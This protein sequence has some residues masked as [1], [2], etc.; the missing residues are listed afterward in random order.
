[1]RFTLVAVLGPLLVTTCVYV[2][3]LFA[4]TGTGL[5]VLLTERSAVLATTVF[6]VTLLLL[7]FGSAVVEET[8][9]VWAR[10]VPDATV[11]GTVTTKVKFAVVFAPMFAVS[12]HLRVMSEQ[13]QPAG[14]ESDTAVVPAGR[15]SV[16][17][18]ALAVAWP[19]L[20]TD[21]V[22]VMLFP[23]VTGFGL[24]TFVTLRSACAA[25]ATGIFT[26]AELLAAF[27]SRVVVPTLTVSEM[28]VPPAV[29]AITR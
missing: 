21:C 28:I 23:A 17:T 19:V 29:P 27:V 26:L 5:G 10:F 18:G 15:V 2:I 12:V 25:E 13:F 20:V 3:V 22:Y 11:E 9:A 14:P 24:P 1:M 7:E 8:E 6:T 4:C 16:R